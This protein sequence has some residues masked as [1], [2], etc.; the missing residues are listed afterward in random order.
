MISL[1]NFAFGASTPWDSSAHRRGKF[2]VARAVKALD[3]FAHYMTSSFIV[4]S[5]HTTFEAV[6]FR[7]G[8]RLRIVQP[9]VRVRHRAL[10][11]TGKYWFIN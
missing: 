10:C 3:K 1:R 9:N 6:N 7:R 2:Y 11:I 8:G 5:K 4:G